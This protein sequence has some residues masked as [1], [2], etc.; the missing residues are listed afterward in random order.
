MLGE[1]T[2]EENDEDSVVNDLD[3]Y[4]GSYEADWVG[5]GLNTVLE[6]YGWEHLSQVI[7]LPKETNDENAC[8]IVK[9]MMRSK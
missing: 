1:D 8:W 2:G 9:A 4:L 6:H 7:Y 5:L 3:Y